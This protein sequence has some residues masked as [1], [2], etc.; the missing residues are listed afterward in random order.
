MRPLVGELGEASARVGNRPASKDLRPARTAEAIESH[1]DYLSTVVAPAPD[2]PGG[3]T[4]KPTSTRY[5]FK[6]DARVPK[7]G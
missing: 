7:L 1:Y 4:V 3:F 6:T 2:A 5:T